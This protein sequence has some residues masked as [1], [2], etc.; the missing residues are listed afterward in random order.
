M[1]IRAIKVNSFTSEKEG[2]NPAGVVLKPSGLIPDQMKRISDLLQVSETAYVFP[3]KNADYHV[4]F[5][6]PAVEVDLCGHATI[7]TFTV[8]GNQMQSKPSSNSLRLTQQTKAGILPVQI[9]FK[10]TA[11][12]DSVF[13]KQKNPIFEPVSFSPQTLAETLMIDTE[14]LCSDL[15]PE[16]VSTGLFTLPVCVSSFSVLKNMKPDFHRVKR[17]CRKHQVGSLHVFTFDTIESKSLYHARNFA[18]LYD[19]NEDPVTGTANGAVCSYLRRHQ[20]TRST[21][22][23]CEQGDIINKSGRV[24]VKFLND[25]VWVGGKATVD[26]SVDLTV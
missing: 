15:L 18:P 20:M 19:I 1:N 11:E 7:A 5:F 9:Q 24:T 2:G 4:R 16:R 22:I 23:I 13:M 17:F 25:S 14:E 10:N 3:S 8:L 6:S 26:E 21:E 12:V